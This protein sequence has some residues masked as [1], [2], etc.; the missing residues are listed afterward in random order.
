[1]LKGS[2]QNI[3]VRFSFVIS[4]QNVKKLSKNRTGEKEV[5]INK[6]GNTFD[7]FMDKRSKVTYVLYPWKE[8]FDRNRKEF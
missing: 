8:K 4:N 1:M 6:W 3:Q 7:S 2:L 5:K